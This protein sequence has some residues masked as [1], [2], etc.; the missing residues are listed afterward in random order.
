[1][2]IVQ[3]RRKE[4]LE[5]EEEEGGEEETIGEMIVITAIVKV[6]KKKKLKDKEENIVT[7]KKET[8]ETEIEIETIE[9]LDRP[10]K[11]KTMNLEEMIGLNIN[12]E[13]KEMK[14]KRKMK[15][16]LIAKE[17]RMKDR[18]P[19]RDIRTT[20]ISAEFIKTVDIL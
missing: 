3:D 1:M 20:A 16:G 5:E 18:R 15:D 10:E 14:D 7:I 8:T 11:I 4:T 19:K 13:E 9:N 12:N 17:M 6:I 2:E